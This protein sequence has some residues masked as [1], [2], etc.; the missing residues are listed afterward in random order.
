MRTGAA[1][2]MMLQVAVWVNAVIFSVDLINLDTLKAGRISRL[3]LVTKP[4]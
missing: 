2:A 4:V 1:M 3:Q